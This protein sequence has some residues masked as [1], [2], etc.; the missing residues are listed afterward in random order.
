ML[1]M[2]KLLKIQANNRT[3]DHKE[4]KLRIKLKTNF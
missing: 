4:I 1:R 2:K 3:S